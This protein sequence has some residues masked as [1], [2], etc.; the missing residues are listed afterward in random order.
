MNK[1]ERFAKEIE[2]SKSNKNPLSE[3]TFDDLH[4]RLLAALCEFNMN[5]IDDEWNRINSA[6]PTDDKFRGFF[7]E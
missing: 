5:S 7:S 2:E 3:E 1:E 6:P 4:K